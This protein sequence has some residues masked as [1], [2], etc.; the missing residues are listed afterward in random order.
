MGASCVIDVGYG[1]ARSISEHH[2]QLLPKCARERPDMECNV[3]RFPDGVRCRSQGVLLVYDVTDRSSFLGVRSWVD[4]LNR[5][6][7]KVSKVLVANKCDADE[8]ARAVTR[9]EGE[10]LA[11][12]YGIPFYETS[13][14]RGTGVEAAFE[15]L[16][17][18]VVKRL[19]V[20]DSG[21]VAPP[22][23]GSTAAHR[24]PHAVSLVTEEKPSGGGCAC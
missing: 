4:D 1:W 21:A 16:A 19:G 8:A 11:R 13:A 9:A 18:Q 23:P 2:G 5:A 15:G 6:D 22:K 10:A 24:D 14:K 3:P 17:H 12:S 20:A 7:P